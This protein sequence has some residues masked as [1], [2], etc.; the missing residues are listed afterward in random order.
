[1]GGT[2]SDAHPNEENLETFD[3]FLEEELAR[4]IAAEMDDEI[5][6]RALEVPPH[7][8]DKDDARRDADQHRE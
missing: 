8:H 5:A 3:R 2:V 1:M 4:E 6:S 7:S